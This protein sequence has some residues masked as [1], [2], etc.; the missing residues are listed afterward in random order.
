MRSP[1]PP[2]RTIGILG[3]GLL[4]RG[5][6]AC[7]LSRGFRVV[8]LD[9]NADARAAARAFVA[10]AVADLVRRGGFPATLVDE[11]PT[12][13]RDADDYAVL[14]GC[15]FV[16]ESILEDLPAKRAAFD[17]IEAVVGARVPVA[18]NTSAL[19][20]SLLQ[21][22]RKHPERFVGMH[23][24]QPCHLTRFL[25]VVRGERTDDVTVTATMNL[26]A[27]A[28]KEPSLV[29]KDV[30]GFIVNRL[31]YAMMREALHLLEAGVADVDTIDRS[32]RNAVGLWAKIAGPFRWMDLTGVAGYAAVMERLFPLLNNATAVPR[33][34]RELVMS[35]ANGIRTGRGFYTYGPGEAQRWERLLVEH[36]WRVRAM[37][38]EYFPMP[39]APAREEGEG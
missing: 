20:I 11:W 33:T 37:T 32:F 2:P 39:P 38:D 17:A 13:Y 18:S 8:G 7:F 28:G 5:M 34:M 9:N 23:S 24:A 26:A 36:V 4:G 10:D 6:A 22:D 27:A 29:R 12:R 25:E 3:L 19:P 15:D 35:G 31:G 16:I 1:P 30:E 21:R 14:R